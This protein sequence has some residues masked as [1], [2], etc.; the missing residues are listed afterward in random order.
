MSIRAAAG[1]VV[2]TY[3]NEAKTTTCVAWRIW[4]KVCPL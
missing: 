1:Q 2:V 4:G 3:A